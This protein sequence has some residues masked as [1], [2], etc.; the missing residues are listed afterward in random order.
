MKPTTMRIGGLTWTSTTEPPR[1][2]RGRL[3]L[4][5]HNLGRWVATAPGCCAVADRPD[6]A[7]KLL[8]ERVASAAKELK[9]E[10]NWT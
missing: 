1:W 8:R 3:S 9:L 6:D 5:Q 10:G 2:R 7:V 4:Y